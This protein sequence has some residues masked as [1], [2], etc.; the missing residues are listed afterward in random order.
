M[1][2]HDSSSL[3]AAGHDA[4]GERLPPPSSDGEA[5][6]PPSAPMSPPLEDQGG[7]N[8][9]F[10]AVPV[11]VEPAVGF[12]PAALPLPDVNKPNSPTRSL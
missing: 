9:D 10:V 4:A 1:S 3:P 2:S 6:R 7:A 11:P 5:G 12:A 8:R